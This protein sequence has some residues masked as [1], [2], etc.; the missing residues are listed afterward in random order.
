MVA[1]KQ[2]VEF[3]KTAVII[4][5]VEMMMEEPNVFDIR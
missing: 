2:T 3:P 4:V 5:A 1:T